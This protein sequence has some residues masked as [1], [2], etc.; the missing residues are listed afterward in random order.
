MCAI[1]DVGVADFL[2]GHIAD[3]EEVPAPEPP[4]PEP[5]QEEAAPEQPEKRKRSVLFAV[6]AAAAL[7]LTGV[8]ITVAVRSA[9]K[10][11][12]AIDETN[13]PDEAFLRFVDRTVAH[14]HSG[15]FTKEE[16][17]AVTALD[18]S[19]EKIADLTGLALFDTLPREL[20]YV[21][22]TGYHHIGCEVR[23]ILEPAA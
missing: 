19:Q 2:S 7:L 13:F 16:L 17:L 22:D 3:A 11:R 18:C 9:Q 10:S 5:E 20:V 14:S 15:S 8:L 6:L 12:I 1:L 23:I 21:F 4:V